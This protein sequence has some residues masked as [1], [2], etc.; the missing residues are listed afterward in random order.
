M[1]ANVASAYPPPP[2]TAFPLPCPPAAPHARTRSDVHA[3]GTVNVVVPATRWSTKHPATGAAS[4]GQAI[5]APVQVSG[6]SQ[7]AALGRQTSPATAEIVRRT[8]RARTRARLARVAEVDRDATPHRGVGEGVD[9]AG[10]G[11]AV[12]HLGKVAVTRHRTAWGPGRRRPARHAHGRAA[13]AVGRPDLTRVARAA[14]R[15]GRA[16][17]A[18]SEA[19]AEAIGA[20]R[21]DRS[22]RVR[23][24]RGARAIAGLGRVARIERRPARAASLGRADDAARR[25]A[26][27]AIDDAH[28]ARIRRR[29]PGAR[30]AV[31]PEREATALD[32]APLGIGADVGL[33]VREARAVAAVVAGTRAR[34]G[35]IGRGR[36]RGRATALR[37]LDVALG[38]DATACE[39][40]GL[41]RVTPVERALH[42]AAVPRDEHGHAEGSATVVDD[43]VT[44]GDEVA[45]R[46]SEPHDDPERAL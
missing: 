41:C 33:G 31:A 39:A 24:A 3:I 36:A 28:L 12:A 4:G 15:P 22:E 45:G 46:V 10:L 43:G 1:T 42:A 35:A 30:H 11:R 6:A 13:A 19:V 40:L 16:G 14:R 5:V 17:R 44:L 20:R 25:D 29:A 34:R 18:R 38:R 9:G 26:R 27:A 2:R 23:R 21:S 7:G 32:A 8:R 37:A